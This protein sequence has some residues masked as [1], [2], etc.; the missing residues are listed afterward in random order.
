[1]SKSKNKGNTKNKTASS[2]KIV[3]ASFWVDLSRREDLE[4]ILSEIQRAADGLAFAA[5]CVRCFGVAGLRSLMSGENERNLVLF[6]IL[7]GFLG[8]GF[9]MER[10]YYGNNERPSASGEYVS[11]DEEWERFDLF[12]ARFFEVVAAMVPKLAGRVM[13]VQMHMVDYTN[14]CGVQNWHGE[15]LEPVYRAS[16]MGSANEIYIKLRDEMMS[17]MYELAPFGKSDGK[18]VG[19]SK[20]LTAYPDRAKLEVYKAVEAYKREQKRKRV[21]YR[22]FLREK[23]RRVY[24]PLYNGEEKTLSEWAGDGFAAKKK[25]AGAVDSVRKWIG[26]NC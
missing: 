5:E 18:G 7:P 24:V 19:H 13:V 9:Y 20:N 25:I 8:R 23:G 2:S 6:D 14:K 16:A 3:R 21:D 1:M 26:R 15:N 11:F 17:L 4:P 10:G 12:A 22:A